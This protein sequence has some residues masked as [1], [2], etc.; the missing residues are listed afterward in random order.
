[1][2]SGQILGGSAPFAAASYQLVVMFMLAFGDGLTAL[3]TLHVLRRL[4]FTPAWQL[5]V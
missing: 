2:M 5:R 3:L 4:A 1:M